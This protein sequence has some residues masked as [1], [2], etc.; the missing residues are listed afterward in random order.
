[1]KISM[2]HSTCWCSAWNLPM[3][4]KF[5]T[6]NQEH[7]QK[8]SRGTSMTLRLTSKVVAETCFFTTESPFLTCFNPIPHVAK[9]LPN[10]HQ[11]SEKSEFNVRQKEKQKVN[12]YGFYLS[13]NIFSQ[14]KLGF[15]PNRPSILQSEK[16]QVTPWVSY[17][18]R[19]ESHSRHCGRGTVNPRGF[20]VSEVG[21]RGH[22]GIGIITCTYI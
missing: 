16:G 13:L 8:K 20:S 3:C 18:R 5:S 9:Q 19:S 10:S 14:G 22:I 17:T 6:S 21:H 7:L 11:S 15:I 12:P 1:M 4:C 2:F